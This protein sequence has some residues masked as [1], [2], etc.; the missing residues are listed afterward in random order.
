[1]EWE[2][3]VYLLTIIFIGY[4]PY[5]SIQRLRKYGLRSVSTRVSLLMTAWFIILSVLLLLQTP[6]M[7]INNQFT[8]IMLFST[9]VLTWFSSPWVFRR[10]GHY[11]T[12]LLGKH[13]KWFLLRLEYKTIVL[14]FFEV[15]FQQAKFA[16]LLFE[17]LTPMSN[18]SRIWWFTVIVSF[19]HLNNIIFVPTGWFFFLMSIPMGL[20]FSW[21][22]LEGNI[23]ITT[24]IHL[25]FY[26]ALIAWYW[27]HL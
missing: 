4:L 13:P 19:L 15:L 5:K 25:W 18:V 7:K 10:L 2:K 17:V 16:Y 14:K 8:L 27:F 1:M 21:L 24:T 26:L 11:P 6:H 23:A 20:L 3:L 22:L 9:T 12:K